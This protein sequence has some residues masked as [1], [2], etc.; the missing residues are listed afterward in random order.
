MEKFDDPKT[1]P[2]ACS[3]KGICKD[4]TCYCQPGHTD[5]DCRAS[6]IR[7]LKKGEKP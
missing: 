5:I 1:C 6:K 3:H 7:D 2:L 4:K